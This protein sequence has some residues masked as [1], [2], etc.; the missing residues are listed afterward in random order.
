MPLRLI[1]EKHPDTYVAHVQGIPGT[2]VIGQGATAQQ[3]LDDLKS[4]LRFHFETFAADLIQ[5]HPDEDGIFVATCPALPGCITQGQTRAEAQQ[6]LSEA[7]VLYL[8]S[9]HHHTESL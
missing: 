1:L 2:T 7:I 4:T 3:A 9:L 6:N 5:L 8:E